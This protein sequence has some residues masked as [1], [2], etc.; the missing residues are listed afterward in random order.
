MDGTAQINA[1]AFGP[2]FVGAFY[3]KGLVH[4]SSGIIGILNAAQL[5]QQNL[6]RTIYL[7]NSLA[8]RAEESRLHVH[9]W[10]FSENLK[11]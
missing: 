6:A 3:T 1:R 2:Y 7:V 8:A 4:L 11:Y 10:F 9:H 5:A